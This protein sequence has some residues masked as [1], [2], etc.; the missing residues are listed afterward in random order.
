VR[1][2]SLHE[3][4]RDS[5]RVRCTPH[6]TRTIREV[7]RH[8]PASRVRPV[9][10]LGAATRRGPD[11][12]AWRVVCAPCSPRASRRV[13]RARAA[14]RVTT[15]DVRTRRT[16]HTPDKLST[17]RSA[18]RREARRA[19]NVSSSRTSSAPSQ[20]AWA[21]ACRHAARRPRHARLTQ[22][23]SRVASSSA[24]RHDPTVR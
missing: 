12:R 15:R 23:R 20:L 18:A 6:A 1:A 22:S 5:T 2:A 9:A 8:A 17:A 13:A 4:G 11:A 10:C 19:S 3:N 24:K 16:A 7:H 21:C 14:T